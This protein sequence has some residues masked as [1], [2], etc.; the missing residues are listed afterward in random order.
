VNKK[1]DVLVIGAGSGL[2]IVAFAADR[3]LTVALVEEGPMGGTCHNRGCIPSKMLIH[4]A[5][6]IE[7]IKGASKFN[8]GASFDGIDFGKFVKGVSDQLDQE[9]EEMEK[10]ARESGNITLYKERCRFIGPKKMQTANEVIEAEKVF[11]VGG[12]RSSVPPI[13]G[14]DK[15]PYL[16]STEALRLTKQ[17]KHMVIVGGGYIAAE[18]AH[19]YGALGT[20]I[21]MLVRRD[22]LL[23]HEDE[24]IATW[25]ADE[26]TQKYMVLFNTEA[27]SFEQ[28]ENGINVKLKGTNKILECDQVLIATGRIPNTDILDVKATG[29]ALDG[30]GYIKVNDYLETNIEGVYALGDIVGIQ[31]FKHTANHQ[32]G[33]A[34]R[35]AFFGKKDPVDYHAI[36]HAV[37]SSP[38]VAGVGKTEQELKDDGIHYKVGRYEYKNTGMGGALKEN[39]LVKV[40]VDHENTILGCHIVGQNASILVHEVIIAMKTTGKVS[41][42]TDS[43]YIHPA[44]S[45]VVQRAFYSIK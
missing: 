9:A 24:E 38:Q 45:E 16:T 43:V 15:I 31:P 5:D 41:A 6:V 18:L 12:T 26:F 17:P 27:D 21:T 7:T 10:G 44:L 20:K 30:K 19:F 25:F 33:Y 13:E 11:I 14:L 40:L 28:M 36:G 34:I 2:D 35:N 3:G 32:V 4:G 1:F 29:V 39:G 37:F 42:I 23:D 8:I 22:K